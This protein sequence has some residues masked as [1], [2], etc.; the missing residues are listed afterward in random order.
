MS[1]SNEENEVY[2]M[3]Y[4]KLNN[5]Y[6]Q[7]KDMYFSIL[8]SSTPKTA[9]IK[10]QIIGCYEQEEY[11]NFLQNKQNDF[12]PYNLRQNIN[13]DRI[14]KVF[15]TKEELIDY[16]QRL[17]SYSQKLREAELAYDNFIKSSKDENIKELIK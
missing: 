6:H 9:T 2:V 14:I 11:L 7:D 16:I 1:D 12:T 17:S 15:E 3:H 5:F 8:E 13:I 10:I 4:P